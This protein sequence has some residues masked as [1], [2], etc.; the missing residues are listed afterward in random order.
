M[1]LFKIK[2]RAG[3]MELAGTMELAGIREL[4]RAKVRDYLGS[5]SYVKL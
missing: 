5:K 2:E 4:A 1:E 3:V